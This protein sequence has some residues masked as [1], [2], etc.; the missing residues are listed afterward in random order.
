MNLRTISTARL[1]AACTGLVVTSV[2]G[3][4][5]ALASGGGSHPAPKPLARA[6]HDGAVAA[7][8]V[9][10]VTARIR[11]TNRL[12]GASGSRG[13]TR[14]WPVPR[15]GCGSVPEIAFAWSSSR[16]EGTFRWSRTGGG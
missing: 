11:F 2:A 10:G 9:D 1:L 12:I 16:S 13:P 5:I 7:H 8:R 14:S 4:A 6:L 3:V 15:A